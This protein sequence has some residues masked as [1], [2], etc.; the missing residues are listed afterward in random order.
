MRFYEMYFVRLDEIKMPN[1]YYEYN[2]K[3]KT[4]TRQ[5]KET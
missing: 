1:Q 5:H 4:T 3:V 2:L